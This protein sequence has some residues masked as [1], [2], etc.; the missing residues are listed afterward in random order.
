MTSKKTAFTLLIAVFIIGFAAGSVTNKYLFPDRKRS[1]NHRDRDRHTMEKFTKELN[2][3]QSQQEFLK[4]LLS[5]VKVKYDSLREASGPNYKTVREYFK[6]EFSKIL[7]DEQRLKYE[8]MN[9]AFA[10]KMRKRK[11]KSDSEKTK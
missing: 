5:T 9:K 3:D 6:N 10:E 8:E 11:E 7:T 1:H 4:D 2:L